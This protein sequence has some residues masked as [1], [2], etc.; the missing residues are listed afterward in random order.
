MKRG[1]GPNSLQIDLAN[2]ILK[3]RMPTSLY[4][5]PIGVIRKNSGAAGILPSALA[6]NRSEA[7]MIGFGIVR[8]RGVQAHMKK[9]VKKMKISLAWGSD[10]GIFKSRS[11]IAV[12][13]A[14]CK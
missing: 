1:T 6:M 9:K 14:G 3:L 10:S 2:I 5:T 13:D 11:A 8:E 7:L 12:I 4:N